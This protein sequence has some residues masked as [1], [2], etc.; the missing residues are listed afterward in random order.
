[1]AKD[2]SL[3]F[4]HCSTGLPSNYGMQLS[5]C[6]YFGFGKNAAGTKE[7]ATGGK[8]ATI[9]GKEAATG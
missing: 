2:G 1:M 6:R 3:L 5:I 4:V 9:G 7:I 8:E